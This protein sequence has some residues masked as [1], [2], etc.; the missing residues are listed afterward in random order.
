MFLYIGEL[1]KVCDVS[2]RESSLR[3]KRM[4]AGQDDRVQA[5]ERYMQTERG[6]R[7]SRHCRAKDQ[8][9]DNWNALVL[10]LFERDKNSSN[11]RQCGGKVKQ[12]PTEGKV[13]P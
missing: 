2:N 7:S 13:V 5:Y 11:N 1:M 12:L 8:A 9:V 3:S 4:Y 6:R 10:I